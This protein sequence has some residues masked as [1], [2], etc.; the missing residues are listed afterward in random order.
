MKKEHGFSLIEMMVVVAIM[1]I[2]LVVVLPSYRWL[3]ADIHRSEAIQALAKIHDRENL[4]LVSARFNSWEMMGGVGGMN[5]AEDLARDGWACKA[6]IDGEPAKCENAHFELRLVLDPIDQPDYSD[7]TDPNARKRVRWAA[8]AIPKTGGSN[9]G[10]DRIGLEDTG[11]KSK[12]AA[13]SGGWDFTAW[14]K[15]GTWER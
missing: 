2:L 3:M 15:T 14:A 6:K 5:I 7:P 13:A 8:V 10:E 4:Y 12:W 11:A 9:E 1:G